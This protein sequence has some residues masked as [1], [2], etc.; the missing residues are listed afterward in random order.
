MW[1]HHYV[2]EKPD[3]MLHKKLVVWVTFTLGWVIKI[4]LV[5]GSYSQLKLVPYQGQS[6]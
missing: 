6:F 3:F 2:E 5:L 1:Y 4:D